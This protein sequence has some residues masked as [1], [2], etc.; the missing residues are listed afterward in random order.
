MSR[1]ASS[2]T[3]A[4]AA[5]EPTVSDDAPGS[6]QAPGSD[7]ATC[8][9]DDAAA[10]CRYCGRPFATPDAHDLHVGDVHADACTTAEREAY[11]RALEAEEDEVFYFHLRVV[12]ALAGLYTVVVLA[13]M[14]ALGSGI[15]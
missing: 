2:T 15:L 10:T 6:I 14:I 9:D 4:D 7:L 5:P 3:D 8:G 12:A 11:E 1:N 13:Y